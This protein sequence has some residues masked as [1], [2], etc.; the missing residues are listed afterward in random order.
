MK[1]TANLISAGRIIL[2]PV[3]IFFRDYPWVFSSLYLVCG[4]SDI[5]DGYIA[6]KTNTASDLG[7]RLD[8]VADFLLF[9]LITT[10]LILWVGDGLTV[11][12]PFLIIIVFI[13][14]AGMAIAA[15]KYRSFAILHTWANKLTGILV[16]AAPI[17]YLA[18]NNVLVFW[19]IV[20]IA[21]LSALEEVIIHLTS[22]ELNL[23]RKSLLV[24]Q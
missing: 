12:L 6:R 21:M 8:S 16:F 1:Y 9:A 19:P 22:N 20:F 17:L 13:R 10:V 7:A 23:D 2:L 3:M 15:L 14:F 4:V 11:F 24:R 18:F 5:A